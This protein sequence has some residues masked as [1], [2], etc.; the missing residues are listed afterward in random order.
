MQVKLEDV[1]KFEI[2]KEVYIE[3]R[4]EIAFWRE[5]S[6]KVTAWLIGILLGIS[7]AA[8]FTGTKPFVLLLPIG[9]LT[10]VAS[11][12]LH[13]NYTTYCE[14]WKR[15]AAVEEA[16]GFFDQNVYID[17]KSLHPKE[18]KTPEVTYKGTAFFIVSIWVIAISAAVSILAK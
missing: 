9:G 15:L 17:G 18:L 4:K 12:Y 8:A 2:L 11:M 6:W 16:L 5:R 7:G 13:K 1:Q 3:Q 14:R 10:I